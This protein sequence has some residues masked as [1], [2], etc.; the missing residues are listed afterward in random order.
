MHWWHPPSDRGVRTHCSDDYLWLPLAA[1]RYVTA[2]GELDVLSEVVHFEGRAVKPE[3][4]SYYDLPVWRRP[5]REQ[6]VRVL[7]IGLRTGVHALPLI[8]CG[9]CNDGTNKVSEHGKG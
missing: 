5:V 2:T 3:E 7:V 4:D 1:C 6:R 9:D 8:G